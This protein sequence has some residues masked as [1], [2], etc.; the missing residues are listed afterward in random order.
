MLLLIFITSW[1]FSYVQHQSKP[2]YN[3]SSSQVFKWSTLNTVTIRRLR[4]Q[5]SHSPH[6]ISM[7]FLFS[8]QGISSSPGYII[9]H[10]SETHYLISGNHYKQSIY[11]KRD[12]GGLGIHIKKK[13][14]FLKYLLKFSFSF[15]LKKNKL[16]S[17][18]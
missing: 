4:Q 6:H 13:Y 16:V 7:K 15:Y 18:L 3:S 5:T 10:S 14:I 1:G 17:R 9:F 11:T 8:S 2:V 12:E